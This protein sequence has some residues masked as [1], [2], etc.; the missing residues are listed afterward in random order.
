MRTAFSPSV[1]RPSSVSAALSFGTVIALT[2]ACDH[3][4]AGGE[5]EA[6]ASAFGLLA[7]GGAESA[8]SWHALSFQSFW[9]WGGVLF[10]RC[11]GTLKAI[12]A[13]ALARGTCRQ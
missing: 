8:S 11:F 1:A 2:S 12:Q 13:G 6:S 3:F 9:A 5:G 4:G 10:H 7:G